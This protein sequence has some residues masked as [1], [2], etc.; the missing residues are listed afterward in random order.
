[1]PHR[2]LVPTAGVD[3]P[4]MPLD[5]HYRDVYR[6]C[7]LPVKIIMWSFVLGED[8]ALAQYLPLPGDPS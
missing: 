4:S 7:E 2:Y 1:M 3:C 6:W 5:R 8:G